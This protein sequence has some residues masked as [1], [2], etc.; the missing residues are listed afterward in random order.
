MHVRLKPPRK[1]ELCVNVFLRTGVIPSCG[2][3]CSGGTIYPQRV[4]LNM[5]A[6]SEPKGVESIG[7]AL[8]YPWQL[9]ATDDAA[10][11][12]VDCRSHCLNDV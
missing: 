8:A 6:E 7:A 3:A 2:A 1:S 5:S 4:A 11:D 10:G 12:V 9:D